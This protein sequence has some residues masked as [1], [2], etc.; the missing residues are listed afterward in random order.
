MA[1]INKKDIPAGARLE[2][3][4]RKDP[5]SLPGNF[6]CDYLI[7]I[8]LDEHDIRRSDLNFEDGMIR[9]SFGQTFDRGPFWSSPVRIERD[10]EEFVDPPKRDGMHAHWDAV[11][12]GGL[13]VWAT[14]ED[15]ATLCLNVCKLY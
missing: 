8:P 15:K 10:G 9:H 12:L 4:W 2:L 7:L 1:V 14:Y 11:H 13:P 5:S 6:I 3:R